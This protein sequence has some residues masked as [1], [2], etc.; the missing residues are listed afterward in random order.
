ML[1]SKAG[2]ELSALYEAYD[3]D[4]HSEIVAHICIMLQT[5]NTENRREQSVSL[6]S[7]MLD[8]ILRCVNIC[9]WYVLKQPSSLS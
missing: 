7:F 3:C 5:N 4:C 2:L 8:V 6:H 1:C 9:L